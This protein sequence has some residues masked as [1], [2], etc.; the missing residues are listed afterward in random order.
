MASWH[1]V[2]EPRESTGQ[3]FILPRPDVC[4]VA[5]RVLLMGP[6]AA[7]VTVE[8]K[9]GQGNWT[10]LYLGPFTLSP[11]PVP[12]RFTMLRAQSGGLAVLMQLQHRVATNR[13]CS[14]D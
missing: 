13:C 4:V 8:G 11:V 2:D 14:E 7:V 3:V 5:R 1:D 6:T 10:T 9:D 12:K